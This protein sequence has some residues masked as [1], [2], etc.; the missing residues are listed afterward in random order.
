M[1]EKIPHYRAKCVADFTLAP[2]GSINLEEY[3]NNFR[4]QPRI[5]ELQDSLKD[6]LEKGMS[7]QGAENIAEI[8]R[9][10]DH[11][12]SR[13]L[14]PYRYVRY[15]TSIFGSA[16]LQPG[17]SEFK[18]VTDISRGIV[19]ESR[20]DIITGGGPGV[21]EAA[22]LGLKEA[23]ETHKKKKKKNGA[24]NNGILIKLPSEE[25]PNGHLDI[26]SSHFTFGTRLN[27]FADKS[28]STISWDG[29]GGTDLENAYVF[30]LKQV[31]HVES[32]F[33]IV[34]KR[35]IWEAIQEA[36]MRVM[37]HA[38]VA[39]EKTPLVSPKDLSLITFAD[40]PDDA[41]QAVLDH[42]DKWKKGVWNK[43]DGKSQ[44]A[45]IEA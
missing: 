36:K 16:R 27:E 18:E 32:D 9:K 5:E 23:D 31:G 1:T 24:K 22:N 20:V 6:L 14:F 3:A 19:S 26:H 30:Q 37:Y 7:L 2:D 11:E 39:E 15:G 38:R 25:N 13:A 8:S 41:V 10:L 28:N 44:E 4:D 12:I 17:S 33:P 34:L 43:L 42:Y 35:A 40:H 21:M 45:L 29:G